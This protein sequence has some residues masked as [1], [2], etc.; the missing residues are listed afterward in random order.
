MGDNGKNVGCSIVLFLASLI[1]GFCLLGANLSWG[2]LLISAP[3]LLATM[4]GVFASDWLSERPPLYFL[5]I[6]IC[7][8]AVIGGLLL[9][10]EYPV[11]GAVI[12]FSPMGLILL[13][14]LVFL[15]A[16]GIGGTVGAVLSES[17][18]SIEDMSGE[19][20][21]KFVAEYLSQNGYKNISLTRSSGD[22]GA[23]IIANNEAN[24]RVCVQCKKYSQ[25]VGIKAVQEVFSAKAYYGCARAMVITNTS[26]TTAAKKLAKQT[27]VE[28]LG[29][30][31][32][33]VK[34]SAAA[35]A[36]APAPPSAPPQPT[37]EAQKTYDDDDDDDLEWI[38]RLEELD[39][40]LDDWE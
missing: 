29:G 9:I 35:P 11:W 21:E 12:M 38:D 25:P 34:R 23:D 40:L 15:L 18:I 16:A 7:I 5:S 30:V 36:Y 28:L 3:F 22:F 17:D 26:F 24:V 33:R 20:Y 4:Y 2:L 8:G 10:W 37:Y 6:L 1:T 13:L 32:P 31:A 39:I 19:D 14:G 27:G